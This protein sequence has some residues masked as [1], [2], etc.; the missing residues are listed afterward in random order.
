[1][2]LSIEERLT[3]LEAD[4]KYLTDLEQIRN[5]RRLYH[6]YVSERTPELIGDLF[7]DDGE[8][9]FGIVSRGNNVREYFSN[10]K[11]RSTFFQQF[12]HHHVVDITGDTAT[13]YC[14]QEAISV[15]NGVA[16][17]I[18]GRYDDDYRRT[19][20]GWKIRK[21]VFD[22]RMFAPSSDQSWA[23]PANRV[24]DPYGSFMERTADGN[25]AIAKT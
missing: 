1:M 9:D 22:V 21:M 13:G 20:N 25:L 5:L 14:Y 3:A 17:N 19:A 23:D 2:T 8:W 16:Y 6:S 24:V 7:T 18:A 15:I 11:E 12:L 10:L 4:T